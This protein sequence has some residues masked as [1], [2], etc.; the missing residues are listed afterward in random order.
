MQTEL[1]RRTMLAGGVGLS[2]ATGLAGAAASPAARPKYYHMSQSSINY[3]ADVRSGKMDFFSF[4]DTCRAL[5]LDG[6]DIH[7]GQL[8]SQTDRAYLKEVRRGCLN[9]GMPIASICVSTEFGRSAEAV[10]KE[11]EK[12]RLAMEVGMFLGAPILRVFVGSPPSPDQREAA[13]RRGVDALRKTAEIGAE[14]GMPVALQNHSGLTSTGDDM[15]R[16][17]REVN[18]PNFTLLLDTGHF[19]G[20]GGP[21][22]PKIPGTTYED[23]YRSIEQVAPLTQF[24]RAKIYTMTPEGREQWIDYD[25]VFAILR[26]VKYNGFISMIY[27]GTEDKATAI[28]RGIRLL[29]SFVMS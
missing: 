18:H 13:F 9:R 8:K 15:L 16:F 12:A 4:I 21:N 10:P 5:D 7:V 19:A 6:L 11:I 24:V 27:E 14:L 3:Q 1:T 26:K 23:Y 22:G 29:R 25:R 28:P 20:R 2:A 17:Q